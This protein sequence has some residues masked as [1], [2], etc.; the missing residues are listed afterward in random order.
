MVWINPINTKNA[1]YIY[2][3]QHTRPKDLILKVEASEAAL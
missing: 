2:M 1:P 3:A